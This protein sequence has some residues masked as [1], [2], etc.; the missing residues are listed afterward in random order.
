M[1]FLGFRWEGFQVEVAG[2]DETFVFVQ[3]ST[4]SFIE[5]REIGYVVLLQNVI[6][7]V[8][9]CLTLLIVVGE[10]WFSSLSAA[11]KAE[12]LEQIF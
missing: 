1:L 5:F 6:A 10:V 3:F 2:G 7:P 4:T 11:L 9:P 12:Q 8:A